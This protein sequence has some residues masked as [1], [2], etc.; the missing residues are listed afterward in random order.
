MWPRRCQS[1]KI[2]PVAGQQHKTML[3]GKL[4]DSFICVVAGE[5]STQKRDIVA[6]LLKQVAQVVGDIVVEQ[7]LHSGASDI[8]LA[9][10]KSISPR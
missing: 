5:D 1:K 4:E 9:I 7:K 2:V 10:S 8:C 6:E 3:A